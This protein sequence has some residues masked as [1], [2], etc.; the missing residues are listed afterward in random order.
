MRYIDGLVYC[1]LARDL[2]E[3]SGIVFRGIEEEEML[4]NA[5]ESS[6]LWSYRYDLESPR[7]LP[8]QS[9]LTLAEPDHSDRH[10]CLC[11]DLVGS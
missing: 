6:F 1:S 9:S 2:R 7:D 11:S 3:E 10:G 4:L 5:G 8:I